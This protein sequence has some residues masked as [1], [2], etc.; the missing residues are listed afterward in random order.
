M[1]TQ[2]INYVKRAFVPGQAK[3]DMILPQ[4]TDALQKIFV[5]LRKQTGHDFSLYKKNTIERRIQR[6]MTVNQVERVED[7]VRYLQQNRI[8]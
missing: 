1:P 5:V 2:L 6:R 7:Y 4:G 8:L 3:P